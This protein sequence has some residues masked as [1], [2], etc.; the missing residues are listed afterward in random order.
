MRGKVYNGLIIMLLITCLAGC[1]T[2]DNEFRDQYRWLSGKW[3]GERDGVVMLESWKWNKHRFEGF[4]C[5]MNGDD[6]VFYEHLFLEEFEGRP[7][8][9]V[10]IE[11]REPVLFHRVPGNTNELVFRNSEHDFPS[12]IQYK[13]EE[14]TSISVSLMTRDKPEEAEISYQLRRFK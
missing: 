12:I 5:E 7:C 14:D 13:R 6:T 2:K 11:D 9:I 3:K 4:A 10:V 8:Y 1:S